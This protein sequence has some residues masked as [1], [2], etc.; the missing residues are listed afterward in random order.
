MK[1]WIDKVKSNVKSQINKNEK[2]KT[3][4][5]RLVSEWTRLHN[6]IENKKS[7]LN[8]IIHDKQSKTISDATAYYNQARSQWK[9]A[10]KKINTDIE[11]SVQKLQ[12]SS[13]DLEKTISKYQKTL[14]Q[15]T[16]KIEKS[17]LG[18]IEKKLGTS[19]RP[20]KKKRTSVRSNGSNPKRKKTHHT[21]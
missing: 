21:T 8:K 16:S 19:K 15:Q 2:L 13:K 12:K 6:E 11:T 7:N 5:D 18:S 3:N 10:Q 14:G 17:L 9:K 1:N 20:T 4:L